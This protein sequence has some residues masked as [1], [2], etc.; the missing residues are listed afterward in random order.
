M[1]WSG[2]G[3]MT[4]YFVSEQTDD[5]FTLKCDVGTVQEFLQSLFPEEPVEIMA[6]VEST[7]L[8]RL[9]VTSYNEKVTY[10][11]N[12]SLPDPQFKIS[13]EVVSDGSRPLNYDGPEI[14][15]MGDKVTFF[16]VADTTY[17]IVSVVLRVAGEDDAVVQRVGGVYSH[18]YTFTMSRADV[19]LVFTLQN[20]SA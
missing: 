20:M 7:Y 19:T 1:S 16:A 8:L 11:I 9:T 18:E 15:H 6:F 14:A 17:S 5:G 2:M 13:R 4:E 12:F 3:E 10:T